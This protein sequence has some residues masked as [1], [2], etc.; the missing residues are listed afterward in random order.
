MWLSEPW[1]VPYNIVVIVLEANLL[2]SLASQVMVVAYTLHVKLGPYCYVRCLTSI[3]SFNS[4]KT[5]LVRYHYPH[6]AEKE[7]GTQKVKEL[8]PLSH[9]Q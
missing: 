6:F 3:I 2:F 1:F 5:F 4:H 8:C 9:S 7:I